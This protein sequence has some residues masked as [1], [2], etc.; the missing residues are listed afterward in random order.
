MTFGPP[1]ALGGVTDLYEL[2]MGQSYLALGMVA[3]ATFSCFFRKFPEDRGFLLAMGIEQVLEDLEEWCFSSDQV[4]YLREQGFDEEY[5]DWLREVRFE[6]RVRG[7]REGTVFY[8][9]EPV[10]EVTASLPVAQLLETLVLNEIGYPTLTATKAARC[11]LAAQGRDCVD[12]ALRRTQG[13]EAGMKF[14]RA[15]YLAGFVATSNVAAAQALGIPPSGT[16]A[17]SYV[18]AFSSE[19]EAFRAYAREFGSKT[20]LLVDTYDTLEG[21]RQATVVAKEMEERGER[22]RAVRLDS[23]AIPS[24]A[25]GTRQILDEAGLQEVEIFVSGGMD[26]FAIAE[27]VQNGVPVD[28]FGVGTGVATS[29]DA[30]VADV[31]YKMVAY[32]GR[33]TFKLSEGKR[34]WAGGKQV[35]RDGEVDTLGL[36]DEDLPGLPLLEELWSGSDRL[37]ED[38]LEAIRAR[39]GAELKQVPEERLRF[40]G[41][42][43]Y[44][45]QPSRKLAELQQ[46]LERAM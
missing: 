15:S 39:I 9:D 36:A 12:F 25:H 45:P 35:F 2:T 31:V 46:A 23:G 6:G 4:E 20:V 33:P 3:P 42:V 30:P 17:H 27:L 38:D 26:E 34:T 7:M 11:V 41:P 22:L 18:T 19:L 16:M 10:L 1:G 29:E 43:S 44:R 24:L 28:G 8:P 5:L 37:V 40:S 32:E 21:V 14:A 13:L